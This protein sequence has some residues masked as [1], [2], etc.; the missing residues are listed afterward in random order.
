MGVSIPHA[1]FGE[2]ALSNSGA[3]ASRWPRTQGEIEPTG[4]CIGMTSTRF[5]QCKSATWQAE[6]SPELIVLCPEQPLLLQLT[7]PDG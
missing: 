6:E 7:A 3:P 1:L 2:E 5:P 4:T